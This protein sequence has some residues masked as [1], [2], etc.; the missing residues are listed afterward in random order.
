TRNG[1][2][3]MRRCAFH[4]CP[5]VRA[6]ADQLANDRPYEGLERDEGTHR[7]AG[8]HDHRNS[9][10]ADQSEALRL[11]W[12]HGDLCKVTGTHLWHHRLHD[13]EVTLTDS[14]FRKQQVS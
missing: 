14:T 11:A 8:E 10:T 9:I 4:H 2:H 7:V 13:V 5:D 12:L 3:V 1:L 6:R